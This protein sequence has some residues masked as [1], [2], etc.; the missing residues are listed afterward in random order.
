MHIFSSSAQAIRSSAKDNIFANIFS[1]EGHTYSVKI[2]TVVL[3]LLMTEAI[4]QSVLVSSLGP[5]SDH[6]FLAIFL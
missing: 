6:S 3:Y 1:R 4:V 2:D 5:V